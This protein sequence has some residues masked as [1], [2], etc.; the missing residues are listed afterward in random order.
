MRILKPAD[1]NAW[2]CTFI[3]IPK[4]FDACGLLLDDGMYGS[5]CCLQKA[6]S[7]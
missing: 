6:T 5:D 3:P 4:G 2:T 1:G 7:A